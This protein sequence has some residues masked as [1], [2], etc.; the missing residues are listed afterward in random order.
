[1]FESYSPSRRFAAVVGTS[2]SLQINNNQG[3]CFG[4]AQEIHVLQE[5]LTFECY[6]WVTIGYQNWYRETGSRKNQGSLKL[7]HYSRKK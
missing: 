5:N 7:E 3:Q 4:V 6:S 1:V 2:T